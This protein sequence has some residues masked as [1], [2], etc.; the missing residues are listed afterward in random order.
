MVNELKYTN[1][2]GTTI[3]PGIGSGV[4][5]LT[6][7]DASKFPT[8]G[9]FLL[10]LWD[11]GTYPDP[12]DDAGREI[13]LCTSRVDNVLTITRA[14]ESTSDQTHTAGE[15]AELR[16][17]AGGLERIWQ[18]LDETVKL[19]ATTDDIILA[20]VTNLVFDA[21][22]GNQIGTAPTQLIGFYGATPVDRGATITALSA[23]YTTGNL[24]SEAEVIAALN[25]TNAAVNQI[26]L[27]LQDLGL[28]A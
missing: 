27:R 16:L 15:R 5:T 22:V 21:T 18:A 6:V 20:S 7:V 25:T 12:N 13:V 11:Q 26:I 4:T 17:T 24:D 1:G 9:E 8:S 28:I 19:D 3:T 23:T 10:T 2:A 14:A